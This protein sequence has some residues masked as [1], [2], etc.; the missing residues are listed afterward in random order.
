MVK[1]S[2][3][4]AKRGGRPRNIAFRNWADIR[5]RVSKQFAENKKRIHLSADPAITSDRYCILN[6]YSKISV[7]IRQ[8]RSFDVIQILKHLIQQF[9]RLAA[10]QVTPD[11]P[12][13]EILSEIL[14]YIEQ[15][16]LPKNMP[17]D[18]RE[19]EGKWRIVGR[20]Q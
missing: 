19:I 16:E 8:Q 4:T 6:N 2:T 3:Q 18:L 7:G 5:S 20:V 1:Q 12:H 15:A 11:C 13:D 17:F 9:P 14:S 10:F